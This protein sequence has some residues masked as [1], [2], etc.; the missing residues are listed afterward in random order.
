MAY[1]ALYEN[2]RNRQSGTEMQLYNRFFVK[3]MVDG[4]IFLFDYHIELL[5][6]YAKIVLIRRWS[7]EP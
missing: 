2:I 1:R 7:I 4:V 6:T 3:L 5:I